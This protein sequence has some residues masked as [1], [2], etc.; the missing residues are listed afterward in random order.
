[1]EPGTWKGEQYDGVLRDI[2]ITHVGLVDVSRAGQATRISF[3]NGEN[4]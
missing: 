2:E 1:M 3:P 4:S